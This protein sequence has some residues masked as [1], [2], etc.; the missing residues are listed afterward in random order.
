MSRQVFAAIVALAAAA[1]L[2]AQVGREQ[3]VE[4]DTAL[5]AAI[6]A[7]EANWPGT[8]SVFLMDESIVAVGSPEL[9]TTRRKLKAELIQTV[10][11]V[12]YALAKAQP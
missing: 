11:G 1:P 3:F 10:R 2:Q 5:D 7:G 8:E 4:P 6:H 9:V 12:G